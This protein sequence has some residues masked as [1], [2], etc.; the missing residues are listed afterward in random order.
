[1]RK[2][3][4]GLM[5]P[6]AVL[7][8]V[9]T[10][11]LAPASAD[12]AMLLLDFGKETSNVYTGIDDPAHVEGT[13]PSSYTDWKG[14]ADAN[15][16]TVS[17]SGGN[18]ITVDLGRNASTAAA[19]AL[20]FDREVLG[21][22]PGGSGIFGTDL[23]RDGIVSYGAGADRDPVGVLISG[24]PAGEY[25]VYVIAHHGG[26]TDTS[27]NVRAGSTNLVPDGV[28]G[29][30]EIT[31][32]YG[33]IADGVTLAG[34]NTSAWI[35]GTNYARFTITLD[36]QAPKLIVASDQDAATQANST[37]SAIMITPVP[38]PAS[39]GILGL[40]LMGMGLRRRRA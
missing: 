35:L 29:V 22:S 25:Y 14:I 36:V 1:M 23:T 39:L 26:N 33:E 20:D 15:V 38:E 2:S 28:A 11:G 31:D 8:L 34:G 7:S 21:V 40:V 30:N 24:L 12:G 32:I 10:M 16:Q 3:Y 18:T 37:L 13:I 19:N 5:G 17:D 4:H 9:A 6:G 27:F